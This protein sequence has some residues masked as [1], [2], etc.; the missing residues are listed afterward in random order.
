MSVQYGR[1]WFYPDQEPYM[2]KF[3][4]RWRHLPSGREGTKYIACNNR[5]AFLEVLTSWNNSENWK[6]YEVQ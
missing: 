6:Y 4:Y 5:N 2:E 3:T 1:D